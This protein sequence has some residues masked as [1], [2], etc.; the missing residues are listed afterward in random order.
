MAVG[1]LIGACSHAQTVCPRGATLTRRVYTG[2]VES[3]WCRRDA[4]RVRQGTEIRYYES[5]V[6]LL[7]GLFVDGVQHGVWRYYWNTVRRCKLYDFAQHV[8]TDFDGRI[9]SEP[10]VLVR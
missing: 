2:G 7:E 6:K 8:W 9:T 5:G 10:Q 4:D 3:E 1:A